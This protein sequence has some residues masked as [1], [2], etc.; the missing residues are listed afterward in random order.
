MASIGFIGLGIMGARPWRSIC[1]KGGHTC[2]S[3]TATH[4]E[5]SPKPAPDLRQWREVARQADIIITIVPD[6]PVED[7]RCSA[8]GV[9]AGTSQARS[10]ST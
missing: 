3:P 9:A 8:N 6:T 2:S 5:T 4:G 1:S 7:A 10:W